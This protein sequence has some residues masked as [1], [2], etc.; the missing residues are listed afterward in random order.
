MAL[1]QGFAEHVAAVGDEDGPGFQQ[2]DDVDAG[3]DADVA[4]GA[5]VGVAAV[6]DGEAV[7][8]AAGEDVTAAATGAGPAADADAGVGTGLHQA[9]DR[10]EV[11]SWCEGVEKVAVFV[12]DKENDAEVV[13]EEA[14]GFATA[15]AGRFAKMERMRRAKCRLKG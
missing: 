11:V 8:G 10:L 13:A 4:V 14:L 1:V 3:V 6:V 5:G 12:V 2:V 9:E 7:D 15:A